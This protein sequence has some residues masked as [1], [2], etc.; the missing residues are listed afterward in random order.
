MRLVLW[1][2]DGTLVDTAGHGAHAF[3]DAFEAVF[4]RPPDGL[5]PMAGR[6]DHEIALAILE[7]SS[8]ADGESHLPAMW[9]E[10]ATALTEKQPAIREEGRALPGVEDVLRELA[11]RDDVLQSLLTGNI[12][13][14]AATKLGAFGLERWL[15]L[16]IGG[17]GSDG[18][19]RSELVQVALD[20]ARE[21]RGVELTPADVVLVGDTPL[22]V[23]AG[24]AAG[25]RVV[26][27]ASGGAGEEDLAAAGPDVVFSDLRDTDAAV[28]AILAA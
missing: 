19:V 14:N 12:E 17:Y 3:A 23:A 15:D 4:G 7:R 8:V 6:T 22:D 9:R 5:V 10:L 16:E 21:K 27:V 26:A 1:D 28:A 20:R 24:H 11:G 18:G 13:A 2:I 25:A